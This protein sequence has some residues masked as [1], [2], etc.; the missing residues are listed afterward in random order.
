M[1]IADAAGCTQPGSATGS[2]LTA[3][4]TAAI[5]T[6]IRAG[7]EGLATGGNRFF[8]EKGSLTP[9]DIHSE[10]AESLRSDLG[11]RAFY[12]WQIGKIVAEPSL[13]AAWGK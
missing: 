2:I 9:L 13:K 3:P 12:Q 4:S 5:I 1:S 11:F 10:S 7:L 6:T 8:G